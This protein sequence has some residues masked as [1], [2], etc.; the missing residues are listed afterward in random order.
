MLL[1]SA[2]KIFNNTFSTVV[3][4]F[5][6]L[7]TTFNETTQNGIE[8]WSRHWNAHNFSRSTLISSQIFVAQITLPALHVR[9]FDYYN[10]HVLVLTWLR[11]GGD[12]APPIWITVPQYCILFKCHYIVPFFQKF[13]K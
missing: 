4:K 2:T 5:M 12:M 7:G 9:G 8:Q 3:Q 1:V 11:H 6:Y 10:T 13:E